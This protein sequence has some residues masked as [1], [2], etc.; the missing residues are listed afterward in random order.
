MQKILKERDA[1]I[2]IL[3]QHVIEKDELFSS[4]NHYGTP[5]TWQRSADTS[6]TEEARLK[7]QKRIHQK[8][9]DLHQRGCFRI[10]RLSLFLRDCKTFCFSP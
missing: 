2:Q 6:T 9:L 8:W 5:Y 1:L 4:E 3:E 10:P 7:R